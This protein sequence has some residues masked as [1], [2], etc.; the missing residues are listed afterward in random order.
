MTADIA[1]SDMLRE[2]AA[3]PMAKRAYVLDTLGQ[4]ERDA[5]CDV[6]G[7]A[8]HAALSPGLAQLVDRCRAGSVSDAMTWRG[9]EAL[10]VAADDGPAGDVI[11]AGLARTLRPVSFWARLFG[12]GKRPA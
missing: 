7:E 9:S 1:L 5:L 4:G 11:A 6:L 2:L 10:L 8:G 3:M 12:G